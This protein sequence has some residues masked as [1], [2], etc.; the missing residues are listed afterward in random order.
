MDVLSGTPLCTAITT[1]V[2][3]SCGQRITLQPH[4][5]L[6][7]TMIT[8]QSWPYTAVCTRHEVTVNEAAASGDLYEV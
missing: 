5:S 7:I 6:H 1:Y 3:S 4:E 2:C 8:S